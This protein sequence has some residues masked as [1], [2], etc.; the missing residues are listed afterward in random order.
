MDEIN[1]IK[2]ARATYLLSLTEAEGSPE[3]KE[4]ALLSNTTSKKIPTMVEI[5]KA[6]NGTFKKPNSILR[7]P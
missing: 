4:P 2:K 7:A 3:M 6:K 1:K 5:T